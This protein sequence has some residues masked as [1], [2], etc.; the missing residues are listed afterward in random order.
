MTTRASINT[1]E[2]SSTRNLLDGTRRYLGSWR[3]LLLLGVVAVA[4]GA[5]L[6]WNWLVAAGIAPVLISVLPCLAMCGLGLCMN[7]IMG[8]SCAPEGAQRAAAPSSDERAPST[9]PAAATPGMLA[10]LTSL[11][12]KR[13]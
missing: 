1:A 13:R 3:G 9:A 7:R 2:V 12:R 10:G 5:A 6:N 8:G 11:L 4:G